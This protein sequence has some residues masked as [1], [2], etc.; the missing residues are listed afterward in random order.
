MAEDGRNA[1]VPSLQG[2]EG[3]GIPTGVGDGEHRPPPLSEIDQRFAVM[4]TAFQAEL[5]GLA[6]LMANANKTLDDKLNAVIAEVGQRVDA[7]AGRAQAAGETAQAAGA[8]AN[9]AGQTAQAAQKVASAANRPAMAPIKPPAPPKFKGASKK[10]R[11]LEWTHQAEQFL[12]S[13]GLAEDEMGVW[14]ITNYLE[15]EAATWWRLH[16]VKMDLG[17]APRITTWGQLKAE[18]IQR[19]QEV[20][21][22]TQVRDE[23]TDLRQGHGPVSDYINRFRSLV[24]E[25]PNETEEQQ[26]Y[27]FL[28][29]L[30]RRIQGDVRLHKP[31]TVERA[32]DLADEAER[33]RDQSR[34][35]GFGRR[36]IGSNYDT[37]SQQGEAAAQTDSAVPMQLG[38]V[39]LAPTELDRCQRE[40]RCFRC[41]QGGHKSIRCRK[42]AQEMPPEGAS[43][44]A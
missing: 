5:T 41:K 17:T 34:S 25:L 44:D 39:S 8:T 35:G 10:P 4:Q 30:A 1:G 7:T 24:V 28:K 37:N 18:M 33:S 11:I 32:M 23:Y 40:G 36:S 27:Q 38:A 21:R 9:A 6:N 13:A 42:P 29:G 16:C 12:K 2:E 43:T 15:D 26:V 19:F 3:A 31:A 22:L 14:H 20:N